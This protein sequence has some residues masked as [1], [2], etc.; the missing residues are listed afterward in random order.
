MTPCHSEVQ[1]NDMVDRLAE[2]E[3]KDLGEETSVVTVLDIK[4][5]ARV[6]IRYKWQQRWNI[7]ES[8]NS[9][10]ASLS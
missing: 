7:G 3:A 9:T 2:I 10:S 1:G 5:Q 4:R 8:E 6:S